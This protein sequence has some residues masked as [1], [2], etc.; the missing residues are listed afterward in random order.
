M[1]DPTAA[2]APDVPDGE[3]GTWWKRHHRQFWLVLVFLVAV[4][5][6]FWGG[7]ILV[8]LFSPTN[9]FK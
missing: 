3:A 9:P 4:T 8:L 5:A 7:L 2:Q 6:P 1:T